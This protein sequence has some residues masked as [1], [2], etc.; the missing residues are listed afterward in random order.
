[1]SDNNRISKWEDMIAEMLEWQVDDL[2]CMVSERD[3]DIALLEAQKVEL[4]VA[5]QNALDEI[6]TLQDELSEADIA[7]DDLYEA[8]LQ[9][10]GKVNE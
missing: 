8:Y 7:H 3:H 5:L 4:E 10:Q 2:A 6:L 9:L 1:M